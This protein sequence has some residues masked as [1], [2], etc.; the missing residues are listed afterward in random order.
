M[1]H[2][3]KLILGNIVLIQLYYF[4]REET[5]AVERCTEVKLL[6]KNKQLGKGN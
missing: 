1:V 6:P 5:R 2:F 4:T 3:T